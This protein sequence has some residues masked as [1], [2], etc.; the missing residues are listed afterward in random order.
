MGVSTWEMAAGRPHQHK[1]VKLKGARIEKQ[2]Q[3]RVVKLVFQLIRIS[4]K[5][6]LSRFCVFFL[7]LHANS[8]EG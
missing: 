4:G 2:N 8:T 5:K 1:E 6:N 3:E 7:C